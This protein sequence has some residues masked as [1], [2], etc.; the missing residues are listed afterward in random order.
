MICANPLAMTDDDDVDTD[1]YGIAEDCND[2]DSSIY[3]GATEVKH[4]GTDQD[5]N[6]Y[7]LTIDI[8]SA[9]YNLKDSLL[10][11][12]A[13]SA[14]GETANLEVLGY[15]PMTWKDSQMN[16]KY[17][18]KG[19]NPGTVSVFGFEGSETADVTIELK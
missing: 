17:D 5:C 4:D 19:A 13:T 16:W 8:T 1:G 6:G 7:D 10:T 18:F 2:N 15:W 11:V 3:P 9:V 14:W 12:K